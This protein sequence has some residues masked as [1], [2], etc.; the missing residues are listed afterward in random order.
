ME[1]FD[2]AEQMLLECYPPL[3][4]AQGEH[5]KATQDTIQRIVDLY[6]AWE[7]P[8]EASLY[9]AKLRSAEP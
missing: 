8:P 1:R 3:A 6:T 4:K 7:K 9:E 2:E 5:H